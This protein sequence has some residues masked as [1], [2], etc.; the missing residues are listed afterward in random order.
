MALANDFFESYNTALPIFHPSTFM[1]QLGRH[2][3]RSDSDSETTTSTI[4]DPA[5]S[6]A[7]SS[8]LALAQR[9]RAEQNPQ[10]PELA[11]LAWAY[12]KN[13]LEA[14][15]TVLMQ[16][17]SLASIQA[18]LA[19]AWFFHGTP[20]PQPFF[21]LTASAVRLCHSAGLHRQVAEQP[22]LMSSIDREQRIRVFWIAVM[23]DSTASLRTGR[24]CTQ[25][26]DD[27]GMPL[28]SVAPRDNLGIMV[29]PGGTTILN[30]LRARSKFAVLEG[31]IY[32][33]IFAASSSKKPTQVLTA[34]V[35]DLGK[36]L[37]EWATEEVPGGTDSNSSRLVGNWDHHHK[38]YI[39]SL[40]LGYH[41][42][43]MTVHSA[44]WQRHFEYLRDRNSPIQRGRDLFPHSEKCLRASH[45]IINLLALIPQERISFMW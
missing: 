36:E 18:L 2:W 32:D 16:S 42:C 1:C 15:L 29:C 19:L 3:A 6:V 12:A 30:L 11:D 7:L 21:F 28:P 8:V 41:S 10:R 43:N 39:V 14:V 37:D 22:A 27:I 9:R 35:K 38:P 45:E 17:V 5:W 31:K 25:S 20:N 44:I 33:R 13:A 24:P 23:F 4:S 34:D 26:V 40:L